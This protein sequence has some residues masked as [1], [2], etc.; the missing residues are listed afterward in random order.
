MGRTARPAWRRG[1][2]AKSRRGGFIYTQAEG[3]RTGVAGLPPD[4]QLARPE[5]ALADAEPAPQAVRLTPAWSRLA[6]LGAALVVLAGI[7]L[8]F[9]TRSDLWLDEALTVNIARLPL[10]RIPGALRRDGA[11]PLYY[12]LLHVWT[13]VFGT[14]D[15]AVRAL[16]GAFGV[17]ALP[18]MW[19]A[20]RRIGGPARGAITGFAAVVLLASSPFAVRYSTET[21]MYSLVVVLVLLGYLALDRALG[22]T[23]VRGGPLVAIALV[24]ALLLYTHYWSLYLVA[25]VGGLLI[26]RAARARGAGRTVTLGALGALAAGGVL[27]VP[28]LPTLAFQLRHTGTPWAE[29]ATFSAMVNAVS[30][31]AGGRSSSGRALGLTFFALAGFGLLGAAIDGH[32]IEVDLR[33]RPWARRV[34]PVTAGTLALAITVGLISRS[35]FSSRYTSVVYPP[36]VLLVAL[37]VAVLADR[38]IRSGVLAAAAVFGLIT[39]SLNVRTNRTQVGQV[40]VAL[41]ARYQPGDVVAYCPDQLGPSTSRL[42]G[43]NVDQVSFPRRTPPQFVNW[44]DYSKVNGSADPVSFANYLDHVAGPQHAVWMVWSPGYRTLRLAC[45][46]INAQLA[47]LRPAASEVVALNAVKFYEH[48]DLVRF[49]RR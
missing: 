33:T 43:A 6:V 47:A 35:T 26:V 9:W 4:P 44:V 39:C 2:D 18:L 15:V 21:R 37:G 5:P 10:H 41:H 40:A 11:P 1:Y 3:G 14:S 22:A 7:V 31:F 28:W 34:A 46:R 24:T 13:A 25:V 19:L 12:V 17:A 42:L 27:F 48:A 49:A 8:R 20:G 32:R 16:S 23:A 45:E 36:F 30:E 38:R 29:P